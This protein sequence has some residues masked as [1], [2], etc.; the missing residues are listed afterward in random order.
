MDSGGFVNIHAYAYGDD[1]SLSQTES[2]QVHPLVVNVNFT[3]S[4]VHTVSG[5]VITT[6]GNVDEEITVTITPSIPL[7]AWDTEDDGMLVV[8]TLL[9]MV[10]S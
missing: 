6:A 7:T 4:M 10:N 1:N 2:I 3:L 9:I 5:Q 8:S